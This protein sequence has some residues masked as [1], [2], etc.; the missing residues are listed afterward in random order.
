MGSSLAGRGGE[1]DGVGDGGKGETPLL[2]PLGGSTEDTA[3]V[4]LCLL[5]R[6]DDLACG[7][8]VSGAS[9]HEVECSGIEF[10]GGES[11]LPGR[12]GVGSAAALFFLRCFFLAVLD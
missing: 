7:G 9:V 6:L 10:D 1:E 3:S 4:K 11:K 2:L 8:A 12:V 5:R